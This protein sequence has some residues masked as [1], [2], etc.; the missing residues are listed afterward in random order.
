VLAPLPYLPIAGIVPC[1][2]GWLVQP[3]RLTGVTI[4]PEEP[5]VL[6]ALV[7]VVDYRPTFAVIALGAPVGF[8]DEPN[9]GYRRCDLDARRLL[10]WPRRT[11]VARVPSR[12]ALQAGNL[13]AATRLEPWLTPLSYRRFRWLREIDVE[14][15]PYH[16]RRLFSA[17]P[18]LSFYLV[19]AD[20][21]TGTSVFWRDGPAERMELLRERLPGLR[22]IADRRPP[23]GAGMSHVVDAAA[24]LWTARRISGKAITRLPEE[25]EWDSLG[26]RMEI[27]R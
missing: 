11:A 1:P 23:P 19:N 15:Q 27:V 24:L 13:A 20:R 10:G 3:A 16:Q 17:V 8:A 12:A 22:A 25:P 5:F 4:V 14:I 6:G 26:R 2:R 21:P 7:D 9:G 18:E